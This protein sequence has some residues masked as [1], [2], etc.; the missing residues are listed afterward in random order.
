MKEKI[1]VFAPATVANVACG[2]DV[3]GFAIESPGDILSVEKNEQNKINIVNH[4]SYSE[5]PEEAEKNTAGVAL[6]SLLKELG[7]KQGFNIDILQKFRPGSGLGSSASS[8]VAAVFAANEL[9]GSLLDKK[10]LVKHAMEGEK[11]ASGGFHADNVGPSML[12]GFTLAR[13]CDPVDVINL[14]YPDTLF[15]VVVHPDLEVKTLDARKILPQNISLDV[16]IRQWANVGGMVSGLGRGDADLIRRS[17]IDHVAEPVRSVLIPG[18][19]KLKEDS[20][21]A[22]ALG[23]G[24]SGSGPSVFS[25]TES[26]ACAEKVSRVFKETYDSMNII[27]DVYVSQINDEGVKIIG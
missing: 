10:A 12:G 1:K 24:I 3:L 20:L 7:I 4:T 25:L 6:I 21:S 2:F 22:G 9:L 26:E 5:I 27:C 14:K 18:F 16:A 17:M 8:A 23:T 11:I 19:D 15:S 13:S